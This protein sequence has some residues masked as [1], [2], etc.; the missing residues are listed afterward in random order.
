MWGD[1]D[2]DDNQEDDDPDND[3]QDDYHDHNYVKPGEACGVMGFPHAGSTTSIRLPVTGKQEIIFLSH[4]NCLSSLSYHATTLCKI[5][6][7]LLCFT[8]FITVFLMS[9]MKAYP[10]P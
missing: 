9:F 3:H 7:I 8:S 2:G 5:V 10:P 6:I 1:V 4:F